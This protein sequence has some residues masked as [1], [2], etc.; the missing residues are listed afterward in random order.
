[1]MEWVAM[2]FKLCDAL[3]TLQRMMNDILRDFLR[4]IVTIYLDDVCVCNRTLEGHLEHLRLVLQ[5]FNGE[6]LI[7]LRLK[8]CF[9]GLHK[10]EYLGNPVP[11]GK[12]SILTEKIEDVKGWPTPATQKENRSFV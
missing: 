8:K 12:I 1:M 4:K 7:K 9:I 5:I 11:G 2:S 3:A 10:I 6:D